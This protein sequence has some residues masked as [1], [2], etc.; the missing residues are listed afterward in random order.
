MR[1]CLRIILEASPLEVSVEL[2]K[3]DILS[4]EG[5]RELHDVHVWS[6]SA[7][8]FSMSAH[9]KCQKGKYKET[10]K[11]VVKICRVAYEILH[12]TIQVEEEEE[13]CCKNDLHA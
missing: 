7:G 12:T 8:K 3:H 10:L 5:V 11:K 9:V 13:I 2:L 4:I 1:D 6:L